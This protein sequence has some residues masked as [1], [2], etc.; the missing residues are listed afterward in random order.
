M[1]ED[2]VQKKHASVWRVLLC[3]AVA[4]I[5]FS[6]LPGLMHN[7]SLHS[8]E[9]VF[10]N[11]ASNLADFLTGAADA[12][13]PTKYYP[14]GGF[15]L[16]MP[17]QLLR[18]VLGSTDR[19]FWGR[20]GG[21]FYF[22]LGT[23]MG[24][25]V[26]RRYFSCDPVSTAVYLATMLFGVMHI[27]Q[28]R[29][30]TGDTASFLLLMA[31]IYF[32]ARGMEAAAPKWFYLAA[33]LSG[34]LTA[35]KYPL[36]FF[37]LIPL[38]GFRKV[39]SSKAK[40]FLAKNIVLSAS[41]FLLGF[42]LLSPKTL[43]SPDFLFWTAAHETHNY[44]AGT[45]LTEVGGPVNHLISVTAYTLLY[46]GFPLLGGAAIVKF[47]KQVPAARSQTDCEY[48]FH[49]LIP[50]ITAGFFVYNLFVTAV[51]LRTYYPFFVILDLYCAAL[52]GQWWREGRK[53]QILI[54]ALFLTLVLRGGAYLYI[55]GTDNG[56]ETMERILSRIPEDSYTEI[57]ELKPG[58]M[59]FDQMDLP[60]KRF[61]AIDLEDA[62]FDTAEGMELREGE[63]LISTYLEKCI[64]TPYYLP[65]SHTR[66]NGYIARWK[67][68]REVNDTYLVGQLYP[69]SY[70]LL[71][72]FW[73]KGSTG[74][75]FEFPCNLFFLR[76]VGA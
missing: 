11:S 3:A 62:R 47:A 15:T 43:L 67:E 53:K 68:F 28:S 40:N 4:L 23:L 24:L 48:L 51:F 6:R 1:R 72:G 38:L 36:I 21:L 65:I 45:N 74:T 61:E 13:T 31:L 46:A 41:C 14:E 10:Y 56:V 30:A 5:F 19:Q 32:S 63:L 69:D 26:L 44:M 76:P 66:V 57:T 37:L 70:Y 18:M 71:F 73:V 20:I 60:E 29:Y 75:V 12:Y 22:V 49:F 34:M 8:D 55:L 25:G 50:L 59:A 27:E 39:F 42:L 52:C 64:G 2:T 16:H 54:A 58:H 7:S 33:G 17:F 9:N 35:V